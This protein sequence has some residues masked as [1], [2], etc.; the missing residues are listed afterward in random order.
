MY[1]NEYTDYYQ[2]LAC[3]SLMYKFLN[4]AIKY[5]ITP[6][7]IQYY[8]S[9]VVNYMQLTEKMSDLNRM[10]LSKAYEKKYDALN[11]KQIKFG[12]NSLFFILYAKYTIRYRI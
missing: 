6:H 3:E 12:D 7:I 1:V 11:N 5:N 10:D 4:R 8:G 2:P 9:K